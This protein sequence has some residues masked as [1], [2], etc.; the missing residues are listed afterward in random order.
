MQERG[1]VT[2]VRWTEKTDTTRQPSGPMQSDFAVAP[3]KK[4]SFPFLTNLGWASDSALVITM[5]QKQRCAR[6]KPGPQETLQISSLFLGT[7]PRHH[8][9]ACLSMRDPV[10]ERQPALS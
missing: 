5:Q 10:E 6:F 8:R 9:L 2:V 4:W 1:Q 3:I 7:L